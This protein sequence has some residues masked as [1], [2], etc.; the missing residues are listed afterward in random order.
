[1]LLTVIRSRTA[2]YYDFMFV[3]TFLSLSLSLSHT[4]TRNKN[5]TKQCYSCIVLQYFLLYML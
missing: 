1:M 4:H 5:F 3:Q 2:S